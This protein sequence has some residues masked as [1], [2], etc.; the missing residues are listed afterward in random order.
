MGPSSSSR[1]P[2]NLNRPGHC[3]AQAGATPSSNRGK[4]KIHFWDL[5]VT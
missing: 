4:Q 1:N 5:P 2:T 3:L